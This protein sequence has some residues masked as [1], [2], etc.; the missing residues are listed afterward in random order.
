MVQ[1]TE[2][3]EKTKMGSATVRHVRIAP[4]KARLVLD[5]I[6]GKQV[7]PALQVLRFSPKKGARIVSKLLHAAMI[8]AKEVAGADVDKL[9]VT[10][11]WVDMGR[12]IKRY[13]PR[14]RGSAAPIRKRSAHITVVLGE[15]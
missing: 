12:T 5:L 13:M 3:D 9:W 15:R 14:A 7:E 6:R 11:G 10:G 4:Q 8:Q 2:V 1:K